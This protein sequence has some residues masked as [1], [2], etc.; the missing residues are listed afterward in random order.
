VI[1]AG[2]GLTVI[3]AVV[4]Q[5]VGKVYVTTAVPADWP[6][7]TPTVSIVATVVGAIDQVPPAVA[8]LRVIVNPLQTTRAP[9]MPDG[10]GLTVTVY[11]VKQPVGNV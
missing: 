4:T 7:T 2:S 5:P 10:N 8:L 9:D 6:V 3:T 1:G 11:N